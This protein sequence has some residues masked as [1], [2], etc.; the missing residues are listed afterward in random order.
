[1]TPSEIRT[2]RAAL[3]TLTVR[4]GGSR[5]LAVWR[6]VV[7]G[8]T[9]EGLDHVEAA[10]VARLRRRDDQDRYLTAHHLARRIVGEWLGSPPGEVLFDRTCARCGA[11][12]GAPRVVGPAAASGRPVPT[13]S[14]TH[15]GHVVGVALASGGP[16]GIDVEEPWPDDGEARLAGMVRAPAD[17][18]QP[19][20]RRLWVSK[21]AVL[22]AAGVGLTVAM[23]ELA[24]RDG[25][26]LLDSQRWWYAAVDAPDGYAAS[27]A[28]AW[29]PP[30]WIQSLR[31]DPST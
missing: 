15:S 1:M 11:Q 26:A 28:G 24:L 12:H 16:V 10:R 7:R 9:P 21:E 8:L 30:S 19:D 18:V 6:H 5:V 14:L 25:S 22:K 13:V 27:V 20:L 31:L 2:L 23:S 29:P 4:E 17:E 3:S